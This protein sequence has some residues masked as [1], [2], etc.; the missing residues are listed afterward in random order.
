MSTHKAILSHT[1]SGIAITQGGQSEP[2][3][4]RPMKTHNGLEIIKIGYIHSR[5][6]EPDCAHRLHSPV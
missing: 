1:L 3:D 2:E 5:F 4:A 6:D